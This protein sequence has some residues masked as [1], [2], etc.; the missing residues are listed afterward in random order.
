MSVEL[1][2]EERLAETLAGVVH[3]HAEVDVGDHRLDAF[4]DVGRLQVGDDRADVDV[5]RT[6]NPFGAG[7]ELFLAPRQDHEVLALRRV[8]VSDRGTEPDGCS[9]DECPGSVARLEIHTRMMPCRG[10][11]GPP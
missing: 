8:R 3:E 9:G 4:P 6:A 7:F 2:V 5:P 10:V 11:R 1:V